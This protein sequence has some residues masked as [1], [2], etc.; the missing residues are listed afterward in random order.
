MPGAVAGWSVVILDQLR[1]T[2]SGR[3]QPGRSCNR[4][5]QGS[6]L[7]ICSGDSEVRHQAGRPAIVHQ[8]I[9]R[10]ASINCLFSCGGRN[11]IKFFLQDTQR[12]MTMS[13]WH[14]AAASSHA[15]RL[16]PRNSR[17]V[18]LHRTVHLVATLEPPIAFDGGK[19]VRL[20]G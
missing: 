3:S 10:R 9:G 7:I 5:F 12:S 17:D 14:Q 6:L 11:S 16:S 13:R 1:L 2:A 4:V 19:P 15:A 20:P 18:L 8:V